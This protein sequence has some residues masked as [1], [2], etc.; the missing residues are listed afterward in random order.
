MDN[1]DL[2]RRSATQ[3]DRIALNRASILSIAAMSSARE[4][5]ITLL[6]ATAV[7]IFFALPVVVGFAIDSHC[8]PFARL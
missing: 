7:L 4:G 8:R 1:L 2:W 6:F 3:V 5:A